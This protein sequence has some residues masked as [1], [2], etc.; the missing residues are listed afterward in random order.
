MV[1][2]F[3]SC[4]CF[5]SNSQ[6]DKILSSIVIPFSSSSALP[7]PYLRTGKRFLSFCCLISLE[8]RVMLRSNLSVEIPSDIFFFSCAKVIFAIVQ[9]LFLLMIIKFHVNLL[10]IIFFCNNHSFL[11][12]Q[13]DICPFMQVAYILCLLF[14]FRSA[15]IKISLRL[16]NYDS[17]PVPRYGG[18]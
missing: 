13:E 6:G 1:V 12:T 3:Y 15:F 14:Y 7:G 18:Q 16:M 11:Q 4:F 17:C 9:P 2:V 8:I 5:E 10:I